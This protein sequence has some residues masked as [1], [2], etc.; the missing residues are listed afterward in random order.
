[1]R[2]MLC[3]DASACSNAS[4]IVSGP[5]IAALN[6]SA[7]DTL[8]DAV[9]PWIAEYGVV[10]IILGGMVGSAIG[11][12]ETP[13]VDC[14]LSVQQLRRELVV[15]EERGHQI[16]IVPGVTCTNSIGQPDVM[17]GEEIQV[18]GWLADAACHGNRLLCLP[19]THTK[20]VRV[21]DGKITGFTTAPTGELYAALSR[22]GVT[23]PNV[24]RAAKEVEDASF[25]EGLIV[26]RK[27]SGMLLH[28]LFSTRSRGLLQ[29]SQSHHAAS[30]LSGLLIAADVQN[31]LESNL[32]ISGP[33]V[34]VGEEDLGQRFVQA[35][36]AA[37]YDTNYKCG[38]QSSLAGF[39]ELTGTQA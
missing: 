9:A 14:P 36:V 6:R 15:F 10:D 24:D 3:V 12:N 13:Y 22:F 29:D 17:R 1:M 25:A 20:W 33:I 38:M 27:H 18:F 28:A 16:A 39:V 19:G 26:G 11:W 37:G 8:F 34:V 30:Y 7:A 21:I 31:A 5:G 32:Q 35:I 4:D 23:V 2:A